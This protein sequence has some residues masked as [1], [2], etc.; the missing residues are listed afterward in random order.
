MDTEK[1]WI[2]VR[3][4]STGF[5]MRLTDAATSEERAPKNPAKPRFNTSNVPWVSK[6]CRDGRSR[7]PPRVDI[8]LEPAMAHSGQVKRGNKQDRPRTEVRHINVLPKSTRRND[9]VLTRPSGLRPQAPC[10]HFDVAHGASW[11]VRTPTR[12][13][14][15]RSDR[16]RSPKKTVYAW[17]MVLARGLR[18][19]SN[20]GWRRTT[21]VPDAWIWVPPAVWDCGLSLGLPCPPSPPRARGRPGPTPPGPT[22]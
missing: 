13:L 22:P 6:R 2:S 12:S 20:G 17:F 9:V 18:S 8:V 14:P 7:H 5:G 11:E 15:A 3:Q 16:P 1:A 21:A 4:L 19:P 10:Q